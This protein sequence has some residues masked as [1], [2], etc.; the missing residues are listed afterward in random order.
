MQPPFF[1]GLVLIAFVVANV[2]NVQAAA[3]DEEPGVFHFNYMNH[4]IS[5]SAL[6]NPKDG[7]IQSTSSRNCPLDAS[8]DRRVLSEPAVDSADDSPSLNKPHE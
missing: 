8:R 7:G 3:P 2:K 1:L 4:I 6:A 5:R